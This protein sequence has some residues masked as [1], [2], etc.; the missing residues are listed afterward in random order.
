MPIMCNGEFYNKKPS[1]AFDFLEQL[2]DNIKQQ[3]TFL[4]LHIKFRNTISHSGGKF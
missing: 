3:E 4:P 1:E 2:A